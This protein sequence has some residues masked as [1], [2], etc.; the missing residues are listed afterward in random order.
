MKKYIFLIVLFLSS[1]A[2][3]NYTD[4][5][6]VKKS[7]YLNKELVKFEMD[8]GYCY[9]RKKIKNG[10]LNYYKSDKGNILADMLNWDSY[11]PCELE[12]K[13]DNKEV[14]KQ[15]KILQDNIKCAYILR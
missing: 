15:I 6:I 8:N 9:Y 11:P 5:T 13:T 10:Y 14:I 4:S 3:P 12:I 2:T 1:C 7:F